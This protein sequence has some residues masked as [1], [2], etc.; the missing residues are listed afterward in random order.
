MAH[1]SEAKKKDVKELAELISNYPII[2]SVN[3]ENLP[4]PQLQKMRETLRGKV[5]IRMTKRRVMK[6]ALEQ[7]KKTGSEK[8]YEYLIGMPALLF[9]KENPFTLYKTIKKNKSPAPA[10][11][12]QTAPKDIIIPAGPTEFS[13][14]PVIGELGSLGVKTGVAGGKVEIKEDAV[15]AKEGETISPEL[16]TML[17]RLK[18]NPMEIG[19]ELVAVLE[20]GTIYSRSVLD[21]DEEKFMDD[22]T[23][24]G[25]LAVNLAV[26]S[27]YPTKDT[28][29]IMITKAFSQ[30]K[31]AAIESGFMADAVVKEILSKA[32]MQAQSLKKAANI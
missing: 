15:V 18:I 8:L 11:A 23:K 13:P 5:V 12:G 27:G 14:G 6:I 2:G 19:L 22:L 4:A 16:A 31:S 24:A 32:E 1:V 29:E 3:M 25:K 17:A 7:A 26:E 9:T 28:I 20:D 21:I 10:K 30:A